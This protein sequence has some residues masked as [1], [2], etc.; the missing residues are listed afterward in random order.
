MSFADAAEQ[1]LE[2]FGKQQPMHYRHIT[3]KA[4]ELGWITT[5]GKSPEDTMNARI[6]DEIAGKGSRGESPRFV[7]SKGLVGLLKWAGTGCTPF[8]AE[9]VPSRRPKRPPPSEVNGNS[10][11]ASS[12]RAQIEQHNAA[13]RKALL[14][15][16]QVMKP[17]DFEHFIGGLLKCL[18]YKDVEVTKPSGD[19]GIDIRG[20][21]VTED[22]FQTH[23]A[24]QVKRW[25]ENVGAPTVQHLRGSL[26]PHERGRI[27]TTSDFSKGAKE[28]AKQS[29]KTP[30]QL[31]NGKELV[32]LLARHSI[33]VRRSS[34]DLIELTE[35]GDGK[36]S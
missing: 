13:A 33:G 27:I 19:K 31:M 35:S 28:E 7:K 4:L 3:E 16:L 32:D 2:D 6:G 8:P 14:A 22:G 17:D 1:I 21:F 11:S 12:I 26:R 25:K 24:I 5:K 29:D 9:Y 34:Y 15:H 18:G 20:V 30:I 10:S 36:S 23:V